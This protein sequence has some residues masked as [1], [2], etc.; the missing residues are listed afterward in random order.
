MMV[1]LT[2]HPERIAERTKLWPPEVS[3]LENQSPPDWRTPE[4]NFTVT[5]QDLAIEA[6]VR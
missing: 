3:A 6:P 2:T 5:V 4:S 1:H